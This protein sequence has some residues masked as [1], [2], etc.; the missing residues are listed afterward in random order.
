MY[1]LKKKEFADAVKS[2]LLST[3]FVTKYKGMLLVKVSKKTPNGYGYITGM[4]NVVEPNKKRIEALLN[5]W[6]IPHGNGKVVEFIRT[7]KSYKIVINDE[8]IRIKDAIPESRGN[9]QVKIKS[10]IAHF[11]ALFPQVQTKILSEKE[12]KILY[13]EKTK[14]SE[15]KAVDFKNIN[16]FYHNKKA[17]LIKER[18]NEE[19]VIEEILHPFV[20]SLYLENKELFD[21]LKLF[22]NYM[23]KLKVNIQL[24]K[25]LNK[26]KEI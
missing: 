11:N 20:D 3:D 6:N 21:A 4:K 2:N 23:L 10:I 26:K 15:K 9:D 5:L 7:D 18:L 16:S 17:I 19:I 14:S 12:A 24:K 1:S 22:L 13:D 8:S 25:V